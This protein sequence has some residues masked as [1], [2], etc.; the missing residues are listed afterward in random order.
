[1][2]THIKAIIGAATL[3]LSQIPAQAVLVELGLVIDGSGSIS[4]TNFASQRSSYQ[5]ALQNVFNG[6]GL[7][8]NVAI[9]VWQFSSSVSTVHTSTVIN[10]QADL[11]AL[12][13]SIANMT[14]LGGG[15]NIGLA[16][17]TARAALLGNSITATRTV[18]D[19]S[20]DG[21]GT[22]NEDAAA[23]NAINLGIYAVNG[24]GIGAGADLTWVPSNISPS[25]AIQITDFSQLQTALE[26]KII[27]ETIGVPDAGSTLVIFLGSLIGLV[28]LRRRIAC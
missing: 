11:D 18:I 1:M 9:G 26:Q 14:Q 2:K 21:F 12:K 5:T 25:F 4:S 27:R 20:T 13:T 19:V 3:A 17:D 6:G 28:A 22:G 23:D 8:G 15:T 24:L 16:I 7:F 10:T